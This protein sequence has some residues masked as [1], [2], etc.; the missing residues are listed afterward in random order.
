MLQSRCMSLLYKDS[1]S[2]EQS[3]GCAE[4]ELQADYM[5]LPEVFSQFWVLSWQGYSQAEW[6]LRTE[7]RRQIS[8]VG[9][10]VSL[11]LNSQ[12]YTL[13]VCNGSHLPPVLLN[14][15]WSLNIL[16]FQHPAMVLTWAP[17]S[18]Q[19]TCFQQ[20]VTFLRFIALKLLVSNG[21][22]LA[23]TFCSYVWFQIGFTVSKAWLHSIWL[24]KSLIE[25]RDDLQR[26]TVKVWVYKRDAMW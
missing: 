21:C 9:H 18:T 19:L 6:S 24:L 22:K 20:I 2:C 13:S 8:I 25:G 3:S 17:L 10:N 7:W 4:H 11:S 23:H 26:C 14:S 5:Y 16:I 15:A 1:D 12:S